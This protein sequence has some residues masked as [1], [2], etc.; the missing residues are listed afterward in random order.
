LRIAAGFVASLTSN[1]TRYTF[2]QLKEGKNEK[3]CNFNS[4]IG[5]IRFSGIPA[6]RRIDA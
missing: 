1:T 6:G 3:S 2:L 4:D 5:R